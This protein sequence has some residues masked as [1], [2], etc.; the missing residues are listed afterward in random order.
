VQHLAS[1]GDYARRPTQQ[2]PTA[3]IA[4][5]NTRPK[6]LFRTTSAP[7]TRRSHST[8]RDM[9]FDGSHEP[10]E[11]VRKPSKISI[12]SNLGRRLS[13]P[14][15]YDHSADDIL[16]AVGY[17]AE[18]SRSRST[19]GVTFMSF[20]LASVPYGLSTTLIYPL[21]GGGPATVL[22]GWILVCSLMLCVAISL[23]EITS[24]SRTPYGNHP[25]SPADNGPL[26]CR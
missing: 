6:Q 4:K 15:E 20:V 9:A 5:R 11:G 19:L 10:K 25:C 24:V 17:T 3:T 22:W 13:A 26:G 1:F 16:E 7:V 18:L 8:Y 14:P 21:M 23:G 12:S 2:P